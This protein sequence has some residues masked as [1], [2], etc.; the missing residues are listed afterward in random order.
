MVIFLFGAVFSRC[1]VTQSSWLTLHRGLIRD[2]IRDFSEGTGKGTRSCE[3]QGSRSRVNEEKGPD[4]TRD[5]GPETS[6]GRGGVVG[7]G[8]GTASRLPVFA[9]R[10]QMCYSLC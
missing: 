4:R 5:Q 3:A 9:C 10:R 2:A 6:P 1:I 8:P 7:D